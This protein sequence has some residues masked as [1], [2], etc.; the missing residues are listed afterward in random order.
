MFF[1]LLSALQRGSIAFRNAVQFAYQHMR[2]YV[3]IMD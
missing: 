3:R 2:G 1:L